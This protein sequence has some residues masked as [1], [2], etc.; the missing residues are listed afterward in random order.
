MSWE[1]PEKKKEGGEAHI[2]EAQRRDVEAQGAEDGASLMLRKVLLKPEAEIEKLVQRNSLF[3]TAC[4]TKDK[5]WKVIIDS[6]STDNLVSTDMVEKLELNTTAHPRPYK[7][8][9]LQKGHQVTIIKQCLVEIKIGRYKDAILCDVIPMDVC[10]ILLG[11]PW[12]FDRNVIH[13]GRKNT[14][15]LEKN[16]RMHM[17]LPMEEKRAKEEANTSILLMSQKELLKEVKEEEEM[18]FTVVRKPRVILTSTSLNDLPEEVREMLD[19]FADIV[20]DELPNSLPPIRSISHHIDVIPEASLPNKATYRLTP[21]ENEEVKN[22]VQELLDK[23][24]V[25]ESLSPCVVPTVLSPKKYG[26]WRMCIDSRAINKITIRYRFPLP[27]MDDLMDCLSGENLFSKI[28]MKSGY[29]Q[30]R[31][32]EGDEWKTTFKMNAGLYE[33]LVMPFV[34]TNAPSTF[35][36]L[37]NEILKDFIGKF[38]V[39]YLDD[40]FVFSRTKEE[41]LRHLTLVMRR[42]QQEKL[43]I[44]LKKYSFMKKELI[45]L[46]F[47]ISSNE[48]KM[49]PEKVKAI[50]EWSSPRSMFEVRRFHGLASFYRKFI[51]DFSGICE[52]MMDIVKKRHKSFKWIEEAEKRF[53][54]L[55]EKITE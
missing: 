32:R 54:T 43:L 47:V 31:M 21:R 8:S 49:D 42:R 55:K 13:Y 16:G 53:N 52:P 48:L 39:V 23:G 51:R 25:R 4:K 44:N 46:G 29:H 17:L 10:H 2:S 1:C 18:Q 41:H 7:V 33:W 11:R 24:L 35:M 14:Y 37:M 3:R 20:V 40:I 34:L 38:V 27:R 36:R 15:T 28:D 9:W 30:I 19:N 5:V 50:R 22:Q 12:K 26:G 45:Y 6:A